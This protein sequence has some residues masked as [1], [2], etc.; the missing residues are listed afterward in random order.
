MSYGLQDDEFVSAGVYSE[1]FD[2][3]R[4]PANA[5]NSVYLPVGDDFMRVLGRKSVWR[6]TQVI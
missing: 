4:S 5:A 3:M 6:L 1:P 2:R